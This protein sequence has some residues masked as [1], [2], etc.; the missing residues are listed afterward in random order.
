MISKILF[1]PF[2]PYYILFGVPLDK[3]ATFHIEIPA[4]RISILSGPPTPIELE[5]LIRSRKVIVDP[6]CT[7][8]DEDSIPSMVK[9]ILE[10][11]KLYRENP[12]TAVD[13]VNNIVQSHT[14]I[15]F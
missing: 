8:Y 9:A 13:F 6:E 15:K 4:G 3:K 7:V 11:E 12:E 14:P 5:E 1:S 2:P 10:G